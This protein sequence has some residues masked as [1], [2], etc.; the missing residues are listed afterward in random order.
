MRLETAA[1]TETETTRPAGYDNS[2]VGSWI[3]DER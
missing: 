3:E 2:D 1:A